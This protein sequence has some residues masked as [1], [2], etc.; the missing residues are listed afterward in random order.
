MILSFKKKVK[1]KIEI[2][3]FNFGKRTSLLTSQ[4]RME[5]LQ[6]GMERVN[7]NTSLLF[8]DK[9][10]YQLNTGIRFVGL[11]GLKLSDPN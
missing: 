10:F 6:F 1:G 7:L 8:D 11:R 9:K 5:D 3:F 2:F 4:N